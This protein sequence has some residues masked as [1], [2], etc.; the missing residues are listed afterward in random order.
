M[1]QAIAPKPKNS[2][3]LQLGAVWNDQ[4]MM[5]LAK[6]SERLSREKPDLDGAPP[7]LDEALRAIRLVKA[8]TP[9]DDQN[10]TRISSSNDA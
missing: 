8:A 5:P 2:M 6:A 3:A 1:R 10:F 4:V 7:L 9:A